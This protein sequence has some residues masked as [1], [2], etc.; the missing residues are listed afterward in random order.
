MCQTDD[1]MLLSV[2]SF[3][4]WFAKGNS[5]QLCPSIC[6]SLW[7]ISNNR[8]A[9]IR[10]LNVIESLILLRTVSSVEVWIETEVKIQC[11]SFHYTF[12]TTK[13]RIHVGRVLLSPKLTPQLLPHTCLHI[14]SIHHFNKS[15][16]T[17][18]SYILCQ[19][20]S[21]IICWSYCCWF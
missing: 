20:I 19:S 6:K 12:D 4:E 18:F 10:I 7:G 15:W 17:S 21:C 9:L 2:S 3:P 11:L 8:F 1:L 16:N 5:L 14:F 13:L